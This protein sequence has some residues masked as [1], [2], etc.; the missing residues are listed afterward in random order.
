MDFQETLRRQGRSVVLQVLLHCTCRCCPSSFFCSVPIYYCFQF[1]LENRLIVLYHFTALLWIA[2]IEDF[3]HVMHPPGGIAPRRKL[4]TPHFVSPTC[5]LHRLF[6][7][8]RMLHPVCSDDRRGQDVEADAKHGS[9]RQGCRRHKI[10]ALRIQES[11]H[12]KPTETKI[13]RK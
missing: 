12:I 5:T 10:D 9:A 11:T 3:D 6:L 13:E 2:W 7:K 1:D 4:L 8:P